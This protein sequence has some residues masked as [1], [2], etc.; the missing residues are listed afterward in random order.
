MK[1]A[2]IAEK[3]YVTCVSIFSM[4][5]TTVFL[6]YILERNTPFL[7][8]ISFVCLDIFGEDPPPSDPKKKLKKI[9]FYPYHMPVEYTVL[10]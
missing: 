4:S 10:N 5:S 6:M 2:V 7:A 1:E 8:H 9:T 3:N